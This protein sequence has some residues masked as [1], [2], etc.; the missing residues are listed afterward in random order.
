M[1]INDIG[2]LGRSATRP[3][4][5]RSKHLTSDQFRYSELIL[6]LTSGLQIDCDRFLTFLHDLRFHDDM[7]MMNPSRVRPGWLHLGCKTDTPN[8]VSKVS[9]THPIA[10]KI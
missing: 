4:Q 7:Y 10:L 2:I 6:A 1:K 5:R 8:R 3:D 9:K